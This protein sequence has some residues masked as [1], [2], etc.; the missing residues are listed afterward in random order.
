MSVFP[1]HPRCLVGANII[2]AQKSIQRAIESAKAIMNIV[3]VPTAET[4]RAA[5][6]LGKMVAELEMALGL[7]KNKVS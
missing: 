2:F 3:S 4:E 6:D 1:V 5:F 7:L